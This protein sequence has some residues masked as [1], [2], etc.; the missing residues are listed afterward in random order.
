VELLT[1]ADRRLGVRVPVVWLNDGF[2]QHRDPGP[3]RAAVGKSADRSLPA[4][5]RRSGE[6][7]RFGVRPETGHALPGRCHAL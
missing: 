4:R 3:P 2:W 5:A 6:H 7:R 1:V